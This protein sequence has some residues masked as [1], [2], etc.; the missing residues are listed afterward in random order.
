MFKDKQINKPNKS[1][2]CQRGDACWNSGYHIQRS[3][4]AVFAGTIVVICY[5]SE[6]RKLEE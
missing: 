2:A 4:I 6:A 5:G 3:G 1:A